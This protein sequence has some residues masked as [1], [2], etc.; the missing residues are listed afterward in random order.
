[1]NLFKEY[2]RK[3]LRKLKHFPSP[4]FTYLRIGALSSLYMYFIVKLPSYVYVL[5]CQT[6]RL[7]HLR[8]IRLIGLGSRLRQKS[9]KLGNCV[10]V[11]SLSLEPKQS[12]EAAIHG[13][14]SK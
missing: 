7:R 9:N 11:L 8:I 13:C 3:F 12:S 5:Y 10:V 2:L 1:M 14:S 4:L 6:S